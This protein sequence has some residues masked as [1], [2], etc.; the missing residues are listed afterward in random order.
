MPARAQVPIPYGEEEEA[1][2]RQA[3]EEFTAEQYPAAAESFRKLARQQTLHQRTTASYIMA[4]R[5]YLFAGNPKPGLRLLEEFRDRYAES[6]YVPES[7]LISGDATRLA[8]GSARAVECY[9]RAWITGFSDT[10]LL[11]RK[12]AEMQKPVLSPYDTRKTETLLKSIPSGEELAAVL[13][14][15]PELTQVQAGRQ[16][17]GA[18]DPTPDGQPQ[19]KEK[20]AAK[21]AVEEVIVAVAVPGREKDERKRAMVEHLL[22]G[23]RTACDLYAEGK[24]PSVRIR[25]LHS[26]ASDTLAT[27]LDALFQNPQVVALLAGAFSSDAK[28]VCEVAAERDVPVLLPTATSDGL[29][30]MGRNIFQLNTP[31]EERARLLA[32]FACLELDAA[33][34]V[35]LA[36]DDSWPREMAE[37]FYE[38]G[39][40]LGLHIAD[41]VYYSRADNDLEQ[42]CKRLERPT[43]AKKRIL[44]APVRSRDDIVRVLKGVRHSGC[45]QT[46]IG[47][48]NWNHP[49][50][51]QREAAGLTVYFEADVAPDSN[52]VEM[53]NLRRTLRRRHQMMSPEFLFGYDAMHLVLN[54]LKDGATDRTQIMQKLHNIH[55]GVRAPVNFLQSR[56]NTAINILC[57]SNGRIRQLES[58]F[59]K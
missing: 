14:L 19:G 30:R 27:S 51:L 8:G 32:D 50:L 21:K 23:M 33:E 6:A 12:L 28:R 54:L 37:A 46:I 41:P 55:H 52:T 44:F 22:R 18:V 49:D 24:Q 29:T 2:F 36:P 17:G 34:A 1:R 39:I 5:A 48:G 38:R 56:I 59:A 15:R 26:D 25:V 45:V 20:R 16:R 47:A 58:F 11:R 9:L 40:K 13:G 3:L 35:V 42:T 53:R 43:G 4:A 31:M 10:L 7:W 57:C